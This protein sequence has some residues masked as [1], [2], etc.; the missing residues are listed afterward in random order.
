MQY[1]EQPITQRIQLG[2]GRNIIKVWLAGTIEVHK[3]KI[4]HARRV[5]CRRYRLRWR[6]YL[7]ESLCGC[8]YD[9][10]NILNR[11]NTRGNITDV[12]CKS[13]LNI[14]LKYRKKP[15]WKL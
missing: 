8:D 13:C 14:L 6:D 15:D 11:K 2:W 10:N 5:P 4:I 3:T 7:S 12:T 9:K 1:I